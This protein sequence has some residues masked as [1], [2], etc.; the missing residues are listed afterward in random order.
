MYAEA[1][2]I[3]NHMQPTPNYIAEHKLV[4]GVKSDCIHQKLLAEDELTYD[5]CADTTSN[6][7][8][9]PSPLPALTAGHTPSPSAVHKAEGSTLQ[10]VGRHG[11]HH[12]Q[13]S[14]QRST[15]VKEQ[16]SQKPVCFCC[17]KENH[18][19][20]ECKYHSYKRSHLQVVFK[21][22]SV[23]YLVNNDDRQVGLSVFHI[24]K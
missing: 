11:Y 19:R 18:T 24:H 4:S 23:Q 16:A 7:F 21:S 2:M 13:C 20:E 9:T 6:F 12:V 22:T 14:P 10:H 17:G 15:T 1:V 5:P 3:R 8:A